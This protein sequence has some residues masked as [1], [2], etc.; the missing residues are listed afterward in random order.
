MAT[1]RKR[2]DK[3]QAIV[4]RR[5]KTFARSF[6]SRAQAEAWAAAKEAE[7]RLDGPAMRTRTEGA[8]EVVVVFGEKVV[9]VS[10][11]AWRDVMD[12][13]GRMADDWYEYHRRLGHGLERAEA[14][15]AALVKL[16]CTGG[17]D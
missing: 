15:I 6:P 12:A 14:G 2:G 3:Y 17:G 7:V 9:R 8:S 10:P 4:R 13:A 5:E 1:F 11:R 16:S